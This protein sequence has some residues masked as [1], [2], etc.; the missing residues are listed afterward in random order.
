MSYIRAG[1]D[2]R[3]VKG[4]SKDYVWCGQNDK[5]GKYYIEDYGKISDTGFIELLMDYWETDNKLFKQ[6][7]IK[8]LADRLGVKL[9]KKPMSDKE[10]FRR[11]SKRSNKLVKRLKKE[12][13][14]K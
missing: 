6:H 1:W 10:M 4:I 12:K 13:V 8:R 14:I 11:M 3:W 7:L 9:R 5:T 2:L